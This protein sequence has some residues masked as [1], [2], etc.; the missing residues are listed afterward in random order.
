MKNIPMDE[1]IGIAALQF[2]GEAVQWHLSFMKYMQYLQSPT[3]NEY[4]MSLVERFGADY[5]DPMEEIKKGKQTGCVKDYQAIFERNL[6]RVNLSQENAI[7]CFIGGLKHELNMAVK[8]GN[9]QTLSQVYKSTRMQEAYLAAIK[10]PVAP[11]Q[12]Q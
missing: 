6:T 1:R 10:Q 5:D 7:S 9:P 11:M 4:M 12:N 8:L 2:E 3:W